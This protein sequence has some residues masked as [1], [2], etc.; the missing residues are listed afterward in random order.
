MQAPTTVR[1]LSSGHPSTL[2]AYKMLVTLHVGK[3]SPSAKYLEEMIQKAPNGV[4][5]EVL[6]DESQMINMLM[7]LDQQAQSVVH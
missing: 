4:G 6:A 1:R 7:A 5:E 2:G 3:D